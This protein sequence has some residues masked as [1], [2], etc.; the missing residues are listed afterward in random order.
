M[1]RLPRR[2]EQ[3]PGTIEGPVQH[4]RIEYRG[5]ES[6]F[7]ETA[8]RV[9]SHWTDDGK[10]NERRGLKHR[11][12][13]DTRSVPAP[14]QLV[15]LLHRHVVEYSTAPDGRLF[16]GLHGGSLSPSIWDRWW[17]LA[18]KGVLTPAQVKS[19]LVR[20]AYDLRHAAASL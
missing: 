14:P 7:D 17:K 19:P 10:P 4:K 6:L 9:G 3:C 8:P 1:P 11:A 16:R 12:R 13:T 2:A 15:A 18:R 20:R 5:G